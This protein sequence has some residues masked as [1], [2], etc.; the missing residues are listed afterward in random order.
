MEK[1]IL[2]IISAFA[3]VLTLSIDTSYYNERGAITLM[4]M[5]LIVLLSFF[6]YKE[7]NTAISR[8][9]F[10]P[11]HLFLLS[12]IV[13][14]FQK[15]IDIMLGNTVDFL[16]IGR[17]DLMPEAVKV[18][19]VGLIAFIV[20]YITRKNG[21]ENEVNVSSPL[22]AST[23][24]YK[25]FTSLT[26]LGIVVFVPRQ[27]LFGGYATAELGNSIFS[28]MVSWCNLF[29]CAFFI[30]YSMNAKL[31][32]QGKGWTIKEFLKDIGWWQNINMLFFVLLLLNVGDRGGMILASISYYITYLAVTG[33]CPSKKTLLFG[34][35]VAVSF[36]SFLGYTK[37]FRDNNTIFE[38]MNTTWEANPDE[39]VEES[40]LPTTNELAGSY[41]CLVFAIADIKNNGN[42]GYGKF[43]LDYIIA[44][45]PFASRLTGGIQTSSNY[46]TR[47]IQG[48]NPSYGNGTSVT[49]DFYLDGGLIGVII[50]M[51]ILGYTYKIFEEVLFT[52][53]TY[54]LWLYCIA[55][56]FSM[57]CVYTP[58]SFY[59][60]SLKYSIWMA[61]IMYLNQKRCNRA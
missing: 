8:V 40:V 55:L 10:R 1:N 52:N 61:I 26:L 53:N 15:P 47:L 49:A 43:Q 5:A 46:I 19:S 12:Y 39:N 17:I 23:T 54:P 36:A 60:M 16:N 29:Y 41:K 57:H 32:N 18:A 27:V 45:I 25:V 20:G 44:C 31:Q 59:L 7:T 22:Y 4:I 11:L 21:N 6:F 48:D 33:V 51:F 13:V 37:K 30:Q 35:M 56:Y 38:R 24:I 42:Y 14:S 28:Y 34:L 58:R 3:F 50:G 2:Y 9:Y